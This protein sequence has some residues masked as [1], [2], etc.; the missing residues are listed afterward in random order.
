MTKEAEGHVW[1]F[2]IPAAEFA[3]FVE[4]HLVVHHMSEGDNVRVRVISE[5]SP[6][7]N[8]VTALPNLEDAYLWLLR[9]KDK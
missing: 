8:A 2:R 5:S 4:D 1:Q 6:W 9:K 3:R 7:E